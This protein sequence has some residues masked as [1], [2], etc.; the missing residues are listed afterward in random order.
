M[1]GQTPPHDP[2]TSVTAHVKLA[3]SD[4]DLRTTMSVPKG[5]V[6]LAE[7][8]PPVQSFGDAVVASAAKVAEGTH[9]T[10]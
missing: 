1:M 7:L 4:W 2:S 3:G 6:R 10:C 9:N 5:P 8:L